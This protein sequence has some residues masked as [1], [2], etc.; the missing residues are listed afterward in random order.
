[1]VVLRV[2]DSSGL[3]AEQF[4][5]I[6][7]SNV[8]ETPVAVDDSYV[9][10]EDTVLTVF[11]PGVL[12]N[13]SDVD[14]DTLTAM[15]VDT[16]SVGVLVL[17]ADGSLTYTPTLDFNGVVTF[18]YYAYD[19]ELA[20]NTATVTVTVAPVNDPPTLADIPPQN[21]TESEP[22]SLTITVDDVESG[23]DSLTVSATS[24]DTALVPLS[25]ISISGAGMERTITI[26]PT[27]GL[28]GTLW[29]TITVSDGTDT[30]SKGFELTVGQQTSWRIYLPVV[31]QTFVHAP[32]L[33]VDSIAVGQDNV[34]VVIA[35]R[36]SAAATGDFWVDLYVNPDPPPA[37]VNDIWRGRCAQGIVWG[38]TIDLAPGETLILSLNDLYMDVSRTTFS[39]V[40]AGDTV[41]VQVDSA[42]VATTYGGVLET[43]EI[44]GQP[45]NNI[46][47]IT[48][49]T[50]TTASV[51]TVNGM[52][53]GDP[54]ELPER[55]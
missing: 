43:H 21:T 36:G 35:N 11:A 48:V 38:V 32:D 30:T 41:Y 39:G 13:D 46:K 15:L 23:A 37:G 52:S 22:F 44:A 54:I 33:V 51:S 20:S 2:T 40:S 34:Q 8:N 47:S 16:V 1:A 4:F 50:T 12:D 24:S 5:T 49:S 27:G 45:Y 3:F 28:T 7:V 53:S 10:A 26:T 29:I 31:M 6:T 14:G 9:I 25:N 18:T 19:G 55:P 42:N 17:N